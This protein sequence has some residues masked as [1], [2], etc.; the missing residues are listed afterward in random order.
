MYSG[1]QDWDT[2]NTWVCSIFTTKY[3]DV[4]CSVLWHYWLTYSLSI[5]SVLTSLRPLGLLSTRENSYA[6]L[7]VVPFLFGKTDVTIAANA[8]LY[9]MLEG[10][11]ILIC[12]RLGDHRSSFL[13]TMGFFPPWQS[14]QVPIP[15]GRFKFRYCQERQLKTR[16]LGFYATL[17]VTCSIPLALPVEW[18]CRS[19]FSD[20]CIG[21]S[22]FFPPLTCGVDG[23]GYRNSLILM[24]CVGFGKCYGGKR[25]LMSLSDLTG[26]Q[27]RVASFPSLFNQ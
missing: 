2:W 20:H 25:T 27:A 16:M 15:G 6:H 17:I 13:D 21:R 10:N 3:G 5:C 26:W 14:N 19:T 1:K 9:R 4:D 24:S 12:V 22:L 11:K 7:Q 23:S 18:S 8:M